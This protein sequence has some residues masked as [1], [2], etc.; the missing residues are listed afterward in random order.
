MIQE[1]ENAVKEDIYSP[2]SDLNRPIAHLNGL[3]LR[4]IA[5]QIHNSLMLI[6]EPSATEYKTAARLYRLLTQDLSLKQRVRLEWLLDKEYS[7][8]DT[9]L[10][11]RWQTAKGYALHHR[12]ETEDDLTA[13]IM[14]NIMY[15]VGKAN[16]NFYQTRKTGAL[17]FEKL[18]GR[19]LMMEEG[20]KQRGVSLMNV[21]RSSFNSIAV[22]YWSPYGKYVTSFME[23]YDALN[24]SFADPSVAKLNRAASGLTV[25][26]VLKQYAPQITLPER[27]KGFDRDT[28]HIGMLIDG[29]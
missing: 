18:A 16:A 15:D 10:A 8:E 5:N 1:N 6:E 23:K 7:S 21:I 11:K 12:I 25:E 24:G 27:T 29:A 9:E 20:L 4:K 19:Y 22:K 14:A 3:S 17:D 2:M 28:K 13:D 26:E